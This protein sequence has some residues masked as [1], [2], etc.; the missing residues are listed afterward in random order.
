M[1]NKLIE[2]IKDIRE[3]EALALVT[4]LLN[5]GADPMEIM[6]S[7]SMAM[8][9]VGQLFE[10]GDYFLPELMMAGEIL[11]QIAEVVKPKMKGESAA[12]NK[13]RVLIGTVSGDIHDIG[14][15]IVAFL[16]NVNGY[17]VC[18]IGVDA[19]PEK[20]VSEI[21]EFRPAVVGMS[22]LLTVAYESM[23]NTVEAIEKAGLRNQVKIMIGGG[24]MSENI[25][26]F[27]G[28]DAYGKDAIAGVNLVKK[29]MGDK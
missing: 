3:E 7:C 19:P 21:L 8:D 26:S 22:G 20:F 5:S 15:D 25:C 1:Y 28:A 16:L 23:K 13:G 18:D 9:K 12:K 10:A 11:K 4:E 27:A 29:W 14:K 2:A 6:N 24:Q 17:D